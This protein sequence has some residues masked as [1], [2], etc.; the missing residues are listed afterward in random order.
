[1]ESISTLHE[2]QNFNNLEYLAKQVV[3]GF[4]T[5]LHKSPFHGF[6]VEFAEHRQYNPGESVK[7]IDWKL[8]GRTEKIYS[9]RYEEETNLRCHIV[10][11]TSSSM[12]YPKSKEN[13]IRFSVL[14][15]A[16]LIVLFKQQRDAFGLTLFS[17]KIDYSSP[18]RSTTVHQKLLFTYLENALVEK[19]GQVKTDLPSVLH[20]LSEQIHKRSLVIIFSDFFQNIE[21]QDKLFAALQHLKYNK[22]EIILFHVNDQVSEMEFNFEDRLYEFEDLETGEKLQLNA[23]AVREKYQSSMQNYIDNIKLKCFSYKIDFVPTNIKSGFQSVL[24]S[25]LIKKNKMS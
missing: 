12:Y 19:E 10:I 8:F 14:S 15:A 5:G 20:L 11:D 6:S 21:S 25:Y 2:L 24:E 4:I 16:A 22:N 1:M 23:N 7:N 13:K 3:E 17:D 18:A 9:K